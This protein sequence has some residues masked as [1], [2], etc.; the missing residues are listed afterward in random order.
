M[1]RF[2]FCFLRMQLRASY[3]LFFPK[4]KMRSAG[5]RKKCTRRKKEAPK[6][7][8]KECSA[9]HQFVDVDV[10]VDGKK[11]GGKE[12]SKKTKFSLPQSKL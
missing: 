11:S 8:K 3:A 7:K 12:D 9:P 2:A 6:F 1:D 5:Q 10:D 4:E